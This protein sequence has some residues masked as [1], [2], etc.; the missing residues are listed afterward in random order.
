[1][2]PAMRRAT[3]PAIVRASCPVMLILALAVPAV[4]D[5]PPGAVERERPA[6]SRDGRRTLTRLPVNLARGTAG[7][8]GAPNAIPFAVGASATA[9]A[10]TQEDSVRDRLRGDDLGGLQSF[11]DKLGDAVVVVPLTAGL[12]LA[13]RATHDTRF[14]NMTYDLAQAQIATTALGGAMK[15][16]VGRE[17]P[18]GTNSHSFP[19]GHSYSWFAMATVVER[20]YGLPVAAPVFALWALTGTSRIAN[21]THYAGDV[22]A[23]A[24]LGYL[25]AR[26]TV[27]VNDEPQ[28]E[29]G[30]RW[31]VVPALGAHRQLAVL[32]SVTF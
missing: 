21:D 20:H 22:V 3:L 8:F 9:L 23:G 13:G 6:P 26:A 24:A 19:S 4:A 25:V 18:N 30:A 17:R 28:A 27:R 1:M 14:R 15:R 5:D 10:F 31:Q 2:L 11:G 29:R 32:A 7:L 16:I 12:L